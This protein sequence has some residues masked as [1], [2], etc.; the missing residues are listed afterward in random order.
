MG[1]SRNTWPVALPRLMASLLAAALL[2][3]AA[4]LPG[5]A[6]AQQ[7]GVFVDPDSPTGKEYALPAEDARRQADP[8]SKHGS[9][10]RE[11]GS[12]PT[13][14]FGVGV[15]DGGGGGDKPSGGHGGGS[16]SGGHDRTPVAAR[17]DGGI[18]ARTE[19]ALRAAT[20]H[21]GPPGGSGGMLAV[22]LGTGAAAVLAGVAGG[23]LIRRRRSQP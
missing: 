22:I 15:G 20:T 7:D 19:R 8:G 1:I 13:A 12:R 23:I 14:L 5:A 11:H 4:T 18:T 16:P 10:G 9:G 2:L 21:P 3:M 17:P 6:M